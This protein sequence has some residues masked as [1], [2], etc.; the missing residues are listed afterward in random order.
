[1]CVAS[2]EKKYFGARQ[3]TYRTENG[4]KENVCIII[5]FSI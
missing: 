2:Y 1:M 3:I 4:L 5:E